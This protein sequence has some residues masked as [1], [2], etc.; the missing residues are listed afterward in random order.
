MR[1]K[2]QSIA[3]NSAVIHRVGMFI[4]S[5]FVLAQLPIYIFLLYMAQNGI[6]SYDFFAQGAFALNVFF[7][8][9][10]LTLA[11]ICLFLIGAITP[12][13][14]IINDWRNK[15][16]LIKQPFKLIS[17][18]SLLICNVAFYYQYCNAIPEA[19]ETAKAWEAGI[20][21]LT[22]MGGTFSLHIGAMIFLTPQTQFK[23]LMITTIITFMSC[24]IYSSALTDAVSIGLRTFSVGGGLHTRVVD[25][26]DNL[27]VEGPLTLLTPESI[28]L[29][30]N[31]GSTIIIERTSDIMIHIDNVNMGTR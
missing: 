4:I 17:F 26:D 2:I 15:E 24:G 5:S 3:L 1:E 23:T 25:Q 7:F 30:T 28:Y 18:F 13:V 29:R 14:G 21:F 20:R 12:L 10:A 11:L 19:P 16:K 8:I 9:T 27:V 22:L 31:T 6:F